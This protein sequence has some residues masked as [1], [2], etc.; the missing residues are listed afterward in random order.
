MQKKRQRGNGADGGLCVRSTIVV[1]TSAADALRRIQQSPSVPVRVRWDLGRQSAADVLIEAARTMAADTARIEQMDMDDAFYGD[2]SLILAGRWLRCRHIS[3]PVDLAHASN[4]ETRGSPPKVPDHRTNGASERTQ[5]RAGRRWTMRVTRRLPSVP[6]PSTPDSTADE[7]ENQDENADA[8]EYVGI[9]DEMR[10]MST[11]APNSCAIDLDAALLDLYARIRTKRT[12]IDVYTD[13]LIE[14]DTA[15]RRTKDQAP[16]VRLYV[17]RVSLG[18]TSELVHASATFRCAQ[19]I[20]CVCRFLEGA[21]GI[22]TASAAPPSKIASYLQR[23]RQALFARLVER[24]VF[25]RPP[26]LASP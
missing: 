19:E 6:V 23:R 5:V 8:Y 12:I 9:E 7:N 16:V 17:D 26:V 25:A 24:G 22:D 15:D 11:I 4:V 2:E 13:A 1:A 3:S 20:E 18:A 10:I 14:K 21:A